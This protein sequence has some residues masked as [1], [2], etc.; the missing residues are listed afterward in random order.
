MADAIILYKFIV[1]NGV[2]VIHRAF[3]TTMPLEAITT[4]Y[5]HNRAIKLFQTLGVPKQD[6]A[7]E[8][9]NMVNL[10]RNVQNAQTK[11]V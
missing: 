3:Y 9:I 10:A 7:T 6:A 2:I 1:F 11:D 8:L 4:Y 5:F